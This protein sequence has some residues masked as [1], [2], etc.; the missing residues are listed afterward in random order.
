[1]ATNSVEVRLDGLHAR[2]RCSPLLRRFTE[3]TRL[4]LGIGFFAPG[5]TK[6]LGNRFT[7]LGVDTPAGFFFEAMCRSGAY[8]RFIGLSQIAASILVLIP[9]TA[10]LGAALFFPI[11]LNIFIITVSMD[12]AG[13][14]VITGLMLL[15]V[16]YLL[17]WDYH[18]FKPLL[19][20]SPVYHRAEEVRFARR[21]GSDH[22]LGDRRAP[23]TCGIANFGRKL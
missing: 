18:K 21:D 3:F 10:T 14:P 12:F 23:T 19:F 1:M 16:T 15:A 7:T 6:A 2:A 17:C 22:R 11:I 13:T 4:M 5:L 9:R 20:E 8:W